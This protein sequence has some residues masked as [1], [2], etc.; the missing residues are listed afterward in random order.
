MK[1]STS[2][3]FYKTHDL[4]ILMDS[5]DYSHSFEK[6]LYRSFLK[7]KKWRT[8]PSSGGQPEPLINSGG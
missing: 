8:S 7:N 1:S 4:F 3:F 2:I 6:N 5:V